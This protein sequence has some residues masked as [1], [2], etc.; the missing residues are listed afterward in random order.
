MGFCLFFLMESGFH[1]DDLNDETLIQSCTL[2]TSFMHSH[3]MQ[4]HVPHNKMSPKCVHNQAH[5][6]KC[7]KMG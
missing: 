6:A 1:I 4:M 3:D 7:G 5:S 2:A